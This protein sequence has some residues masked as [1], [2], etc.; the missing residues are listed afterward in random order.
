M[1]SSPRSPN[2]FNMVDN[3]VIHRESFYYK[4]GS[5][6]C[7]VRMIYTV[8]FSKPEIHTS[9]LKTLYK[10]HMMLLQPTSI[11]LTNMLSMPCGK[12]MSNTM[13]SGYHD[14]YI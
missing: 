2:T 10:L 12:D 8:I 5:A 11:I 14:H 7:L 6:I 4:D 9:R 1:Y 3:T 13:N